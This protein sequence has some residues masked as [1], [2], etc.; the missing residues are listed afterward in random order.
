MKTDN[1]ACQST[2][3]MVLAVVMSGI[4]TPDCVA[5]FILNYMLELTLYCSLRNASHQV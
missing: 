4:L 3:C 1:G 5:P 2:Y